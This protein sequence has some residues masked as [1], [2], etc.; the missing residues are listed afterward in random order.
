MIQPFRLSTD[1]PTAAPCMQDTTPVRSYRP[2]SNVRTS[3]DAP[4]F[5]PIPDPLAPPSPE[6]LQVEDTVLSQDQIARRGSVLSPKRA[7]SQASPLIYQPKKLSMCQGTCAELTCEH[8]AD[9]RIENTRRKTDRKPL[10]RDLTG[11]SP[12]PKR[13]VSVTV[14]SSANAHEELK[15]RT[16]NMNPAGSHL[17]TRLAKIK[18]EIEVLKSPT[19]SVRRSAIKSEDS[20]HVAA[21]VPF[22]QKGLLR[23]QGTAPTV[24]TQSP[25]ATQI[26]KSNY[27]LQ[28]STVRAYRNEYHAPVSI[29]EVEMSDD[30][31]SSQYQTSFVTKV[32]PEIEEDTNKMTA[33]YQ[34]TPVTHK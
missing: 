7:A 26:Q 13:L 14:E 25:Y 24:K 29:T 33:T 8:R 31:T 6:S 5:D 20:P 3:Q 21:P 10:F 28:A 30:R 34:N 16:V 15:M 23:Y 1:S 32:K 9:L 22:R 2:S 11:Y 19:S 17:N 12:A 4:Q 18:T 27:T